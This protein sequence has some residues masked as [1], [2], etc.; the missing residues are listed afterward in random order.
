MVEVRFSYE[1]A[2]IINGFIE[3]S[4]KVP[5]VK[6]LIQDIEDAKENVEDP[7]MIVI[8]DGTIKKLNMLN[9]ENYNKIISSL[10]VDTFAIYRNQKRRV[11]NIEKPLKIMEKTPKNKQKNT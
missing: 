6:K 9:E 11:K 10:P 2:E 4:G 7:E 5:G 8:A 1:E 3:M